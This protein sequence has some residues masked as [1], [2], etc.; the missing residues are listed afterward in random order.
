MTSTG[1]DDVLSAA[2]RAAE[3]AGALIVERQGGGD[4]AVEYKQDAE[5]VTQ[6]DLLADR[7]ITE[8]LRAAFPE[9]VMLSEESAVS[10]HGSAD[11][12]APMWVVDPI[13]GTA[14]YTR[15]HPYVSV[16]IAYVEGGLTRAAV[17]HA[18]FLGETFTA[19]RGRGAWLNGRPIAVGAPGGL[20]RAVVSTGFPHVRT[21][22]GP[23]MRRIQ[24]LLASCQD[25]RRAAS[26]ALDICWVGAGRLDAHTETL[27]PW[28][29]AAASLIAQEAGA[30]RSSLVPVP[31]DVPAD[32]FG[33]GFLIAAPSIHDELAALL[34]TGDVV[35]APG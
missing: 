7:R 17:V 9:I 19:L 24:L 25:I 18:P 29:V 34:K 23:L 5:P 33:E 4:I 2:V 28:D 31:D 21:D 16:A 32:L 11:L 14:N 35:V 30:V 1:Y 22:L 27:H 13:D 3:S 12:L 15:G 26:P 10:E 6:S 20:R 8:T